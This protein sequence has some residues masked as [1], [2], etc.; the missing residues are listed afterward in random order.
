MH[1]PGTVEIGTPVERVGRSCITLTQGLFMRER[2]V[3]TGESVVALMDLTKRRSMLLPLETA[4][5][6]EAVR[7]LNCNWTSPVAGSPAPS[8]QF[9]R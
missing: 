8:R 6:L 3:T 5:A 4:A 9:D 2:C 1:W 7:S